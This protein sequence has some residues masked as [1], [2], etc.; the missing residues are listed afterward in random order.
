MRLCS[1]FRK[2]WGVST[3]CPGCHP[4]A[5]CVT[6]LPHVHCT[7]K[8]AVASSSK[9]DTS[10][11]AWTGSVAKRMSSITPSAECPP[12]ASLFHRGQHCS[13]L[14]APGASCPR[15]ANHSRSRTT[16][17]SANARRVSLSVTSHVGESGNATR[18]RIA[19]Q[20]LPFSSVS[21]IRCP[22]HIADRIRCASLGRHAS[23]WAL[24]HPPCD[25]ALWKRSAAPF[26]TCGA[27]NTASA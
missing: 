13:R 23:T 6:A 20:T 25:A 15:S 12:V 14:S 24:A 17:R 3:G 9:S 10:H 26:F 5:T 16:T 18:S 22:T 19:R 2:S 4:H 8:V 11:G 7:P 1:L 27:C 21:T